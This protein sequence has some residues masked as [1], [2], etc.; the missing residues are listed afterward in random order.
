MERF[1]LRHFSFQIA[2]GM[3]IHRKDDLESS[4]PTPLKNGVHSNGIK[5]G[6]GSPNTTTALKKFS[7]GTTEPYFTDV[8]WSRMDMTNPSANPKAYIVKQY[9]NNKRNRLLA[10]AQGDHYNNFL[11]GFVSC[12]AMILLFWCGLMYNNQNKFDV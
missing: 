4:E 9:Y 10:K 7:N 1:W 3:T 2:F 11:C 12:L 5:N 8:I 6:S